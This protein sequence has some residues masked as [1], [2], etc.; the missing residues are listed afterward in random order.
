[1][2]THWQI[3]SSFYHNS[4]TSACMVQHKVLK[5]AQLPSYAKMNSGVCTKAEKVAI[6]VLL[7]FSLVSNTISIFAYRPRIESA[8]T[9]PRRMP[10]TTKINAYHK[11]MNCNF[12]QM[13]VSTVTRRD[14]KPICASKFQPYFSTLQIGN[15]MS[16]I[17]ALSSHGPVSSS[18]IVRLRLP[19][20]FSV[21]SVC[22]SSAVWLLIYACY[23]A[24][25]KAP[26]VCKLPT[27]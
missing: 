18:R 20:F 15:W 23:F 1:M 25:L 7:L 2:R 27:V 22:F 21:L 19:Y 11:V 3:I 9:I 17:E 16:Q 24:R 10:P 8:F 4:P 26:N 6:F 14:S 5:M 12:F 13:N